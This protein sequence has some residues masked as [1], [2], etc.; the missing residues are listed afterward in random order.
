[1]KAHLFSL[2]LLLAAAAK[3]APAEIAAGKNLLDQAIAAAGGAKALAAIRDITLT[4]TLT[5]TMADEDVGG[6]VTMIETRDGSTRD[7]MTLAGYSMISVAGPAAAWTSQV[8]ISKTLSGNELVQ[9]QAQ[10]RFT[11]LGLLFHGAEAGVVLRALPPEGDLDLLEV[12][13]PGAD[14]IVFSLDAKTHLVQRVKLVSSKDGTTLVSRYGLYRPE[15]GVQLAHQIVLT[16]QGLSMVL[17]L[18]DVKI[19]SGATT[20]T[21]A[22]IIEAA[23]AKPDPVKESTPEPMNEITL[24]NRTGKTLNN[25]HLSVHDKKD[26]GPSLLP[27]DR[28]HDGDTATIHHQAKG[29]CV[30]DLMI[31]DVDGHYWV[32]PGA[33][34]CAH[35]ALTLRA[36]KSGLYFDAK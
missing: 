7:E 28:F 33:D 27:V 23:T 20:S 18:T 15:N 16:Q 8:G 17:S 10:S 19:N 36:K 35:H 34:L 26:W 3:P 30:F 25:L 6:T 1:M 14:P 31:T 24:S 2:S 32:V 11:P 4:G 21:A 13:S 9:A 22:P 5:A 12:D 29:E